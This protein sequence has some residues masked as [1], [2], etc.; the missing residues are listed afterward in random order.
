[1]LSGDGGWNRLMELLCY[2]SIR[3]HLTIVFIVVTKVPLAKKNEIR[4]LVFFMFQK[5]FP[6]ATDGYMRVPLDERHCRC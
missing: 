6:M 5:T 3:V 2:N 4:S 1:M